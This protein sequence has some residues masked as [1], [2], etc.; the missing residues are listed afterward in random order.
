MLDTHTCVRVS[1][2]F[3][4]EAGQGYAEYDGGGGGG[5]FL[6]AADAS[7]GF[8]APSSARY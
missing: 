6:G 3:E 7:I 1:E 2:T 8:F 4:E 5:A